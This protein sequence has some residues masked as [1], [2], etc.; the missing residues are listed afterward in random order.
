M[1]EGNIDLCIPFSAGLQIIE[2][3]A[4]T[5]NG[6]AIEQ[7]LDQPKYQTGL[8]LFYAQSASCSVTRL[9]DWGQPLSEKIEIMSSKFHMRM[10]EGSSI[11]VFA[12]R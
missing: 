11:V 9:D 6:L 7:L 10:N 3:L 8:A 2:Y 4:T 5:I 12:Y 1:T